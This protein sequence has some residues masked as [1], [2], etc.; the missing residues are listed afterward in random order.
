MRRRLLRGKVFPHVEQT[1]GLG[2]V[3]ISGLVEAWEVKERE[4]EPGTSLGGRS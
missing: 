3:D 4:L 2:D 1:K